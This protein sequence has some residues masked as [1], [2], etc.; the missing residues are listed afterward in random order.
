MA[1]RYDRK[2][3]MSHEIGKKTNHAWSIHRE[4]RILK[5]LECTVSFLKFYNV[6]VL[7]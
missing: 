5:K 1:L 6:N 4:K 7:N 2:Y 3:Q